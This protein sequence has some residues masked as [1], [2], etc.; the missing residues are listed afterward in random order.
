MLTRVV[1][2]S[3]AMEGWSAQHVEVAEGV[4]QAES[5]RGTIHSKDS[6]KW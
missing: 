6:C 2:S 3:G 1:D 5:V 4:V